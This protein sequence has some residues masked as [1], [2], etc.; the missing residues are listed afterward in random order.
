MAQDYCTNDLERMLLRFMAEPNLMLA[1][2]ELLCDR[3][4]TVEIS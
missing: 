4:M 1:M 2:L 3:M